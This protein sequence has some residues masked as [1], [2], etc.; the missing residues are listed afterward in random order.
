MRSVASASRR[1]SSVVRSM[2]QHAVEVV[3][4]VLDDARVHLV[5]LEPQRRAVEILPFDRHVERALDRHE[6][7]LER[8]TPFVGDRHSRGALR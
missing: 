3:D 8:Q 5:E 4:L 1:A 7:P 2:H 6:H